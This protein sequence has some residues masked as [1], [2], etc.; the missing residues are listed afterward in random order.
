MSDHINDTAL[1]EDRVWAPYFERG[2]HVCEVSD[3]SSDDQHFPWRG[4]DRNVLLVLMLRLHV[5]T[6]SSLTMR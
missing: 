6:L 1:G 5:T 3:A 2:R 4:K